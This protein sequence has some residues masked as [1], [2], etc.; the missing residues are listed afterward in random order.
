MKPAKIELLAKVA[1]WRAFSMC[2]SFSIAYLF[3]G[4]LKDSFGIVA[5][6]G[7]TLTFLQW[8]FEIFWDSNVRLRLR[9]LISKIFKEIV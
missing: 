7:V 5:L 1:A 8:I 3:T 4:S 6:T 9:V 2:Y